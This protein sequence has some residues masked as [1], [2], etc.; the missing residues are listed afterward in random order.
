MSD[1]VGHLI[2]Y[3]E[4]EYIMHAST[5]QANYPISSIGVKVHAH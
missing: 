3:V 4:Y 2:V 1:F 5:R